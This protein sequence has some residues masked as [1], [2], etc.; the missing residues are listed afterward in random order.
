MFPR[1]RAFAVLLTLAFPACATYQA[2]PL[3]PADTAREFNQRTLAKADLCKYLESNG[4]AGAIACPLPQWNLAS[5]TLAAFFYSPDLAVADAKLQV[6]KA[7]V[8]TAAERPNPSI[9]LGPEYAATAAPNFAPWALGTFQINWPIET[10]GKRGYRVAQAQRLADA[11]A[12]SVGEAAWRVRSAVRTALLNYL[13]AK[14]E[15]A[16]ARDYASTSE[17]MAQLLEQRVGAGA[18]SAPE[19]NLAMANAAAAQVKAAQAQSRVPETLNALA[20]AVGVPMDA[21]ADA[22]FTWPDL[23][24]PPDDESLTPAR[25]QQ[26]ALLNRIDLRRMLAEYAAADEALKLEIAKQYPDVNLGGSY[27]WEVNENIFE[28]FPVVTLP[29][30]N[31]NQGPIAEARAKRAQVAAEFNSLQDAIIGQANGALTQYRG[32]LAGWQR[33]SQSA[34]FARKR[35][36]AMREAARLGDIDALSLATARL[37]AVVVEQAK[38]SALGGAQA[39]MGALEDATERPL[40]PGDLK[41]FTLPASIPYGSAEQRP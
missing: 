39:A 13:I 35:L 22:N 34:V 20:T 29:L 18:A 30:M 17:Q 9:G 15:Y 33:G 4:N 5:L 40:E 11:A 38:L 10:A 2:V 6:A 12:L 31:Q 23:E 41:S 28:L 25:V 32:A 14:Q 26:L 16:L 37:E 1:L 21:L 24:H 19:A 8:I 7:A 27:S 36:A 3:K